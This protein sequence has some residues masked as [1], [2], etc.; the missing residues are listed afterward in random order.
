MVGKKETIW[1]KNFICALIVQSCM[2][3]GQFM[4]NP[5]MT[6]YAD[7]LGASAMMTGM[8]TAITYG[9]AFAMRPI[10]GPAITRYNKKRLLL[11]GYLLIISAICTYAASSNIFM[12]MIGRALHGMGLSLVGSLTLTI[13]GDSLPPSK[14]ASGLGVFG[15]G[16]VFMSA[17]APSIGIALKDNIGFTMTFVVAAIIYDWRIFPVL[18]AY[19]QAG[20][21]R[22]CQK[23]RCMVQKYFCK[24]SFCAGYSKYVLLDGVLPVQFIFGALCSG[25]KYRQYRAIFYGICSCSFGN[26][27]IYRKVYG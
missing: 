20:G 9:V 2:S 27:S 1:S 26:S 12:L 21:Q 10:T 5:I 7:H 24:R 14:M 17:I 15:M 23:A 25:K 22:S 13:A 4:V 16:S 3:L 18:F 8:T 11:L 6:T 19:E